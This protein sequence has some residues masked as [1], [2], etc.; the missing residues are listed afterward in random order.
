M[1]TRL[2]WSLPLLLSARE[3]DPLSLQGQ[4]RSVIVVKPRD[5][6][7]R[8]ALFILRDDYFLDPDYDPEE[9]LRQAR[10]AAMDA[11]GTT[12]P[13][14]PGPVLPLLLALLL[15]VLG[16]VGLKLWGLL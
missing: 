2:G 7:F 15:I 5:K 10:E 1:R 9:L 6:R 13:R 4:M 14:K 16:G 8:E 12:S 11:C 3:R